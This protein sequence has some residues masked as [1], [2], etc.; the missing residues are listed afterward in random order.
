MNLKRSR[1]SGAPGKKQSLSS[2]LGSDGGAVLLAL[3]KEAIPQQQMHFA[4]NQ[5]SVEQNL[6]PQAEI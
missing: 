3:E 6:E 5:E 4:N 1:D 2:E